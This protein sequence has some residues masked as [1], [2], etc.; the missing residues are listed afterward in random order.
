MSS[1]C[2]QQ[3]VVYKNSPTE[4]FEVTKWYNITKT[5]P[6]QM[7]NELVAITRKL[8]SEIVEQPEGEV[9][10]EKI[11]ASGMNNQLY[12]EKSLKTDDITE[13]VHYALYKGHCLDPKNLSYFVREETLAEGHITIEE[14]RNL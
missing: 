14:V 13:I 11:I 5:D 12:G 6:K 10:N 7:V 4:S 2:L 8:Y 9:S 1:T 3:F